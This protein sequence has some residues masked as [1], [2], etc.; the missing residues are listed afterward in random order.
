MFVVLPWSQYHNLDQNAKAEICS[1]AEEAE[2]K[3]DSYLDKVVDVPTAEDAT[4]LADAFSRLARANWTPNQDSAERERN[5]VIAI[6]A[7]SIINRY[8]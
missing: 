2:R 8:T 7:Q 5:S 4:L 3:I 1:S 6:D